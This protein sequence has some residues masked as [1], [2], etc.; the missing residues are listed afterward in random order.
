MASITAL[1]LPSARA[2]T[3]AASAVAARRIPELDGLRGVAIG[4]VVIY[5]AFLFHVVPQHGSL[6]A[7]ALTP[8]RIG[9][10]G[11]DLFFVL[12]G[13]LIGGILLDARDAPNYFSTFYIRRFFRIVPVYYATLAILFALS[14]VAR[15]HPGTPADWGMDGILTLYVFPLFVHNIWMA[16]CN[17][18]GPGMLPVFWSLGVEEQF[19]LTLPLLVRFCTR[20]RL[21]TLA[22]EAILLAPILRLLL[23]S[24]WPNHPLAWF[25]LMPCRADSLCFGVLAAIAL[26][27]VAWKAWLTSHRRLLRALLVFFA[28]GLPFVTQTDMLANGLFMVSLMLSWLAAFYVLVLVYAMTFSNSLLARCLRWPWLRWLG[29]IAYGMYLLHIMVLSIVVDFLGAALHLHSPVAQLAAASLAIAITLAL[30]S[31]SWLYFEKPLVARGHRLVYQPPPGSR[32]AVAAS[33]ASPEF[34]TAT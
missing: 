28:A 22:I 25:V 20:R 29:T 2:N 13:F 1:P 15:S 34:A 5:H 11:V 30:S 16:V 18:M 8:V 27:N 3:A 26:R 14:L 21:A 32:S 4:M 17:T 10:S 12:S 7:Y 33:E 23:Y 24:F 19:Y 31:I 6:L 9:W